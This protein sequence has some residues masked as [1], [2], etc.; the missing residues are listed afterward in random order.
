MKKR[1]LAITLASAVVLGTL[2]GCGSS[3]NSSGSASDSGVEKWTIGYSNRDDTDTFLKEVEDDFIALVEEDD[4][5]ELLVSD[6]E[7]DAQQQLDQLDNFNIQG[8]NA[9][10]VIPQDGDTVVDH[11]K[12]WNENGVPVFCASVGATG[13]DF[14][15]VGCADYE[16]S[17][18]S[19]R[20]AYENL[21]KNSKVLYLG[22]LSGYDISTDR[23]QGMVDALAER[24]YKDYNG[25]VVNEDG[26][27]EVLSWQECMYTQEEG[28]QI[29]EDWIQTFDDFDAIIAC[30]DLSALGAIEALQGAGITDVAV[31]GIDGIEDGLQAVKDGS[32]S[33]TVL[34][35]AQA[36]AQAMYDAIKTAQAGGENPET[37]NVETIVITSD[38]VDDYLN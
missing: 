27:I 13:G 4:T 12:E 30:N 34:Q 7:G 1:I 5:L 25:D 37:I 21:P 2:A 32:M 20:W 9:A 10:I 31:C 6:A 33:C 8:I 29:T 18:N 24:L 26:D 36:E 38:N 23:R 19:A 11:I 35:D 22:G 14:T 28:M 15:Y 3:S 16:V 17:Y